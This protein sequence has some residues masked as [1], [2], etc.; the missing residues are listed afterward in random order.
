LAA[1]VIPTL[2]LGGRLRATL[3]AQACASAII[4]VLVWRLLA[5]SAIGVPIFQSKALK[6]LL[7][8]GSPF[9]VFAVVMALQPNVDAVF[10]SRFAPREAVGWLAVARRL[11]GVLVYP[12]AALNGALY[13][14]LCRLHAEDLDSFRRTLGGALRT[15]TML[16]V[17]LALGCALYPNVGV[18]IFSHE[19]F[20]PAED[21]LRILSVFVFLVYFTMILGIGLLASGKQKAWSAV[22]LLCVV[23]SVVLDPILVPLFQARNGNGG[24]GVCISNVASEVLMLVGGVWLAPRGLFGRS[25][26]RELSL[27]LVAGVVMIVLSRLL[28]STPALPAA[29]ISV[30]G[31]FIAL[32]A[33]GGLETSQLRMVRDVFARKA[34][35]S[36]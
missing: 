5:K 26:L 35:R 24:L 16:V 17:P 23:V 3:V 33:V 29:L 12:A 7:V 19:Q 11:V 32:W 22:Q 13:P 21:N 18:G 27:A 15:A 28:N 8:A 34:A 10:L 20:A 25:L 9:V 14:T 6:K 2:M 36:G 31:Y 4:V 30:I 1:L